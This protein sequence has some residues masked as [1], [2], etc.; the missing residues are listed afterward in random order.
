M[1]VN[2]QR[3]RFLD[4]LRGIAALSVVLY[5][6]YL[7]LNAAT[8]MTFPSFLERIILKGHLGVQIFFVLSGFVIAYSIRHTT[9]SWYY[10]QQFFIKRSIR[11]DPPYWAI[12]FLTVMATLVFSKWIA[13]QEDWPFS[14]NQILTNA[15]YLQGFFE[16]DSINPVAWTL[17]IE[18][19]LYLFF[20]LVL[21]SLFWLYKAEKYEEQVSFFRSSIF[22]LFFAILLIGSLS[23][24]FPVTAIQL[25]D[26][27]LKGIFFPYWYSFFIGAATC[28]TLLGLLSSKWLYLYLSLIGLCLIFHF[29][30]QMMTCLTVALIIY[31][32]GQLGYLESLTCSKIFQY[33]GRIS[34]SLYLIHWLVGSNCIHF[35]YKRLGELDRMKFS[36]IYLFSIGISIL[37]AHV[38]YQWIE[39][40]CLKWS[41]NFGRQK[42]S[43]DLFSIE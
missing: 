21:Q 25:Q 11:L 5:H 34:F 39:V 23:Y 3:L 32:V 22:A 31:T 43:S 4:A 35:L 38:F 40:P 12:L 26:K 24:H 7:F 19:Q 15:L 17:C 41:K 10:I 6:Q 37:A 8:S 14:F 27:A 18:L 29:D 28:W 2:T 42:Q 33:L 9:L 30:A 36:F 1:I 13:K 16:L 20:V